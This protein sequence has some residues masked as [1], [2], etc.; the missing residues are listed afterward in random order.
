MQLVNE[1][2][3]EPWVY[4]AA[5]RQSPRRPLRPRSRSP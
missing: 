1:L 4:R 2:R 5:G 3:D